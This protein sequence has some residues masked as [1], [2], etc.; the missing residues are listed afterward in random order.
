[1]V[2][3]AISKAVGIDLGTTNSVVAIMKPT[4]TEIVV[5]SEPHTRR[6]TTP[7]CVWKDP[8]NGQIVVGRKAFSRIGR[9]PVPIR[10]IKRSMGKQIKVELTDEEVT[11]EQI[12]ATIL[13]EMKR[14]IEE[15]VAH[16]ATNA[17]EWIVDRAIVTVPAYFDQ[18]QIEAT[19]K[20]A[21]M[22]GLQVLE[23]LHEPTAAACYH[24]WQESIQNG[25]FMVYDFGGGTFDVSILRCTEGTFEV[26]G[27]S[28]NNLLG[29]DDIDRVLA[30]E[31]QSRLLRQDYALN[32]DIK[33]DPEDRLRFDK[34]KLLAEETKKA[35]STHD[36]FVL[37]NTI[38]LQDKDGDGVEFEMPFER[39]ELEKLIRPIVERTIPYCY[40]ALE[41]AQTKADI[42]LAD[43][44]ALIL[45]GGTTHIPLVREIVRNT[46]CANPGAQGMRAKCSEPVYKKVDTVVA[47][48]AAI[49]AAAIGGLTIYNPERT[50][51]VF[52]RGIGAT[53]SKQTH[54]GGQVEALKPDIDLTDGHIRLTIAELGFED[55]QPLKSTGAFGFT[56][57]Q[58]Q[59]SAENLLTFDIFDRN[60][61]KVATVGRPISQNKEALRP[62]GGST[63]TAYC[64]KAYFLDVSIAGEV[65]RKNLISQ[66]EQ[67]PIKGTFHFIH[68]GNTALLRFPLYQNKKKIQEIKISVPPRL[69]KG[70]P[71]EFLIEVD[72]LSRIKV[73]GTIG[74]KEDIN[75]ENSNN[76][77][78]TAELVLPP[79]RA[80]PTEE[81]AQVLE[82]GFR[83]LL[84]DLPSEKRGIVEAQYKQARSSYEDALRREDV[85][86]AVHDF[87][88][89]EELVA[90]YTD[91]EGSLQ[92]PKE[93]FDKLVKE[94]QSLQAI[95]SQIDQSH[96]V[97]ELAKA[98]DIQRIEGEQAFANNNRVAYADAIV[99]LNAINNHLGM[100]LHQIVDSQDTRSE[101]EKIADFVKF[102]LKEA[103]DVYQLAL[104][105]KRSDFQSE[106]VL[107][108]SQLRA[109]S[110]NIQGNA[111]LAWQ[112]VSQACTRLEQIRNVLIGSLGQSQDGKLV[113][114]NC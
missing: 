7:S 46:F 29:G 107:I 68:P 56:R 15:D 66:G 47:L 114:D 87:E 90:G 71:I 77:S 21:E 81:E 24:C 2:K 32:L 42:T 26:L 6:E 25:V 13:S 108:K 63:G 89:M 53:A 57:I 37:R 18:P 50:V 12:S 30:E 112:R 19:R 95:A 86:H 34:L 14:Q 100:L 20:A 96:K 17:S 105:E 113:E 3:Y 75:K 62:T 49:R 76:T 8:K 102:A 73:S 85:D 98:I 35:L 58:L 103:D 1:M 11:P 22:A 65:S 23:L 82:Q 44:D 69:S 111:Y 39:H 64:S 88:E 83:K 31:L 99:K 104:A 9:K 43:V 45:A 5:H 79:E 27:I 78:F 110:Q 51:R 101:E 92:P 52:F 67:L 10:S 93:V 94:C 59:P 74:D 4:D 72:E 36:E 41:L 109:S 55:E 54:I 48:G 16:F 97:R 40:Q 80:I 84:V 60:G 38:T 70:T 91:E 33:N 28:G 106:I 61:K